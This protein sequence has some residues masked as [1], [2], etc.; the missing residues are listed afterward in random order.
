[1]PLNPPPPLPL[2]FPFSR[3]LVRL[4]QVYNTILRRFP[5]QEYQAYAGGGNLFPT[6]IAVPRARH[7]SER[8]RVRTRGRPRAAHRRPGLRAAHTRVECRRIAARAGI[9][10]GARRC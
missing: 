10:P 1:M 7:A 8:V 9:G 2:F 5:A 6:T 3:S 4:A